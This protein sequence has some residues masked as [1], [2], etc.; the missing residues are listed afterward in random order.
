MLLL[1]ACTQSI[2]LNG[3]GG[4]EFEDDPQQAIL[5]SGNA[6][7]YVGSDPDDDFDDIQDA[8][9]AAANGDW[10]LVKAGEYDAIDFGGKSV[11]ITSAEGPDDT[12]IDGG[13]ANAAVVAAHGE[14]S[15]TGLVGFTITGGRSAT[16]YVEFA[17]LH[18]E[19][20]VIDSDG[21]YAV[22][23][24][25]ADMELQDVEIGGSAGYA[26]IGMSRGSLQMN[27]TDVTCGGT[28][29]GLSVGHGYMQLDWSSI[30]CSRGSAISNEHNTGSV[31]R[32]YIEGNVY[33]TNEDDHPTDSVDLINSVLLGSYTALYG[34]MNIKNSVVD[35]PLSFT[36]YLE[37]EGMAGVPV[38][39]NSVLL[40]TR[41][42]NACAFSAPGATMTV[43]NNVIH[44]TDALCDG[45]D[46]SAEN[47]LVD[48]EFEDYNNEDFHPAP[49]S[50][51][52]DAGVDEAGYEDVDGSRNDIGVYGGRFSQDGG[53]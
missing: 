8:I 17:S 44:D 45:V 13:N 26:M 46:Y 27:G 41:A 20:S 31:L 48:P 43:R 4:T 9:D 53:W 23:G 34:T 2:P 29:T 12:V 28:T 50:P 1:L 36:P 47:L 52:I 3:S 18:V 51:M 14:T 19:G 25:A 10:I 6:D 24:S 21:N 11:W 30:R 37:E 16:V 35:G 7:W 22:Y 33:N 49:G 15:A 32:S 5:P 39:E 40:G 42:R 38:I